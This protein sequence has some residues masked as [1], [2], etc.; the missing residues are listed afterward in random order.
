MDV[1]EPQ[2]A[3]PVPAP[4]ASGRRLSRRPSG[5]AP[6]LPH[7]EGWHRA[8]WVA[9]AVVVA[10]VALSVAMLPNTAEAPG[11]LTQPLGVDVSI[12]RWA[13][14]VRT[15]LLVDVSK[16][17]DLLATGGAILALRWTTVIV[18]V[19]VRR[20]RHLAVAL[21]TWA[22]V[23]L[24]FMALKVQLVPPP[25]L[26]PPIS[27]IDGPS[28]DG[29]LTYF[30]PAVAMVALAV[31][32][33]TMLRSLVPAERR[34]AVRPWVIA[35]LVLVG[36]A[37]I[38]L[39]AAYPTATLYAILLGATITIVVFKW[40][41][42]DESFPVSYR[43]GGNAAHL[44]LGGARADAVK[45]AMREQL[46]IEVTELKP[47]GDEGSGGSTPL[48]MTTSDGTQIFG[49][50]LATSHVRAD[51]WYRVGRTILYGQLEDEAPFG[52]VR[53]LIGY[54]DYAL[55]LL[56]DDG[57]RVAKSYGI[58][59]LTPNREYLLPT[60][61]FSG[62]QTLGHAE[63]NDEII[64]QAMALVRHLWDAGLAHRDIK[65]ANLLVVDGHLQLIDVSGLEVRPSAW[66]QAVDLANM[67][68]VMALRT[69]APRVYDIALRYF[70]PEDV[71][72]AF[73]CAVG[74]A[75]PTE[76]QRYLKEDPRNLVTEFK[77]LA[78]AYPEVSIQR[79]S[80]R[81]IGL[82]VAVLVGAL[83]V[84]WAS[85]SVIRSGL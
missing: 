51:R 80:A 76:L 14:D 60:E 64:D 20:F 85:V 33:F 21:V 58:V 61:F 53:R 35:L 34:G 46:G 16:V 11:E 50:I 29:S 57:I 77:S 44:D 4:E 6:P 48:L 49:K 5:E 71:G 74:L 2:H 68:L 15:P 81:R 45:T 1:S 43:K 12:L 7:D 40:L 42:A 22:V 23:D 63:V 79:W 30:F 41:V 24:V 3:P 38:L 67:M 69:D 84:A 39:G 36:A 8:I 72:E 62:S 78:P 54:E 31:T 52:S 37:R 59:E 65:P 32:V 56:D 13:E 9:V 83:L 28:L 18:L 17:L 10:G 25:D 26:D 55:R 19:I 73:A 47:F 70:T 82:T 66:R 27:V 75:I